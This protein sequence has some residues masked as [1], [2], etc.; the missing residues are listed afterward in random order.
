MAKPELRADK[1]DSPIQLM[2]AW[3]VMLIL[4]SGVLLTG[5]SQI[6]EPTWAAGY[7]VIFTSILVL[8]V[9]LCVLLM[10]TRFRLNLQDGKEYAE[11]LKDQNKYSEGPIAEEIEGKVLAKVQKK[12]EEL[13]TSAGGPEQLDVISR[14]EDSVLYHALISDL[15]GAEDLIT[16]FR[17][18]G[19]KADI[20]EDII[21]SQHKGHEAIWLGSNVP[22]S[23][24]IP[25]I[26]EAIKVWPHLKYISLSEDSNGPDETHWQVYIG[27]ATATARSYRQIW[28]SET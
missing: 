17:V 10:L 1:I 13:K 5:A 20:Y 9:L 21:G 22:P 24:A 11:W 2:A 23:V 18:M 27:G 12:F 3:F 25:I 26:R 8:I 19:I 4:L 16:R 28:C 7:L 6:A 15:Q 14:V